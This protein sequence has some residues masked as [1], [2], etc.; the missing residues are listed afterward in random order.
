MLILEFVGMVARS[1]V[2]TAFLTSR[3]SR[4]IFISAA[5]K[6]TGVR[7]NSPLVGMGDT[8]GLSEVKFRTLI[9]VGEG[10]FCCEE[11][12]IAKAAMPIAK[13]ILANIRSRAIIFGCIILLMNVYQ[14]IVI[15]LLTI[16]FV[17]ELIVENLNLKYL[18]TSIP[19]EFKGIYKPDKYKKSQL[20][21]KTS[22]KFGLIESGT[23]LLLL[24]VFL[25]MGGFAWADN[26]A[27]SM[28]STEIIQGLV[29]AGILFILTTVISLPFSIYE[30]FVIEQKF[31]FNKSSYKT[32]TKDFF[33]SLLLSL[34]LGGIVFS[35][36]IYFFDN[37]GESA[38]FIAWI[39]VSLFELFI[40]F[41]SPVVI[42]P[43]FN[44]FKS[45]ESLKLKT[46]INK[47]AKKENFA[48]QG[49][50]T[51]DG[52][53]RSTKSNAFFTGLGRFRRIVLFDT[54]IKQHTV[55]ELV[56]VLAHEIGHYKKGHI[57]KLLLISLITIGISLWVLSLLINNPLIFEAFGVEQI[58]TYASLIFV[59][60][61]ISP[62]F[63][64]ISVITNYI[65][66]KFE[67]EADKYA[68]ESFGHKTD[69]VNALK[70]LSVNNLS[71]LTP[72]PVKVFM[73]YSHPPVL[74]RIMQI[75]KSR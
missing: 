63:E 67:F 29:F 55:N 18:T 39:F 5:L 35:L 24:I 60:I 58:S 30:T 38:W 1:K 31:G 27:R 33:V 22:T 40:L 47:F 69:F 50:Y 7:I 41:I 48:L 15:L 42:M 8:S 51:M 6:L 37:F 62:L 75:R 13:L 61:F 54:L 52:S 36:L 28:G 65:S 68:I 12:A 74:A 14:L 11:T 21:L 32:F 59:F 10:I 53:K 44:K 49:I 19:K 46:E 57:I 25:V 70:K 56:A 64:I 3:E 72:H 17:I 20:Y 4:P 26:I 9:G 23:S 71:N 73:D 2:I 34:V 66:R 45:L 16:P 43:L